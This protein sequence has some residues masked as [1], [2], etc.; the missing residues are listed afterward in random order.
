MRKT[1]EAT[2][3]GGGRLRGARSFARC[4]ALALAFGLALGCARTTVVTAIPHHPFPIWVSHLETG[5]TDVREVLA[6][7]GEPAEIEERVRGG[8]T[9][10]YA[11]E[12]VHWASKD[13][14]RPQYGRDGAPLP[15]RPSTGELT[16]AGLKAAGRIFDRLFFYPGAQPKPPPERPMPATV[17][18][19]E[20]D[21]GPAGTLDRY[22]YAPRQDTVRVALRN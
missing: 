22:Y 4:G 10:Y 16:G 19:L 14:N 7:F 17:H 13:P 21:F 2:G 20:L 3:I 9:W 18:A 6:V 15:H 1:R 11:Y 12:E 8:T 5:R